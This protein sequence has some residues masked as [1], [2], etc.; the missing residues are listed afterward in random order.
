MN[1]NQIK[2][3]KFYHVIVKGEGLK[4]GRCV[5]RTEKQTKFWLMNGSAYIKDANGENQVFKVD[6]KRVKKFKASTTSSRTNKYAVEFNGETIATDL[7]FQKG[8]ATFKANKPEATDSDEL[9]LIKTNEAN[10]NECNIVTREYCP[11]DEEIADEI[12]EEANAETTENEEAAD[13]VTAEE[14][15]DEAAE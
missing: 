1:I 5:G 7:N 4:R 3:D 9:Y 13:E 14:A 11:V 15:T 12:A 8:L 2:P 10:G 6:P